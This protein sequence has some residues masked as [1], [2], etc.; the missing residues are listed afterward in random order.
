[1]EL[2][3]EKLLRMNYLPLNKNKLLINKL[4]KILIKVKT[5]QIKK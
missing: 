2:N 4:K 3:K 5:K 1:M